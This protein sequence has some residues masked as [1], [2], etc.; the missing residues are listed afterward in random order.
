MAFSSAR[1]PSGIRLSPAWKKRPSR[2]MPRRARLPHTERGM[3]FQA[4]RSRISHGCKIVARRCGQRELIRL[5][6][7]TRVG[8]STFPRR[9]SLVHSHDGPSERGAVSKPQEC[10]RNVFRSI[11]GSAQVTEIGT[12]ERDRRAEISTSES[13]LTRND[14][15][16]SSVRLQGQVGSS[17]RTRS[18]QLPHPV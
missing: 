16:S 6:A 17:G 14:C 7:L 12:S 2:G 15:I 3:Y 4:A 5:R 13:S 8:A 11:C 1:V 18:G 9:S 10:P